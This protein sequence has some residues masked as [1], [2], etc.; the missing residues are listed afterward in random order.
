MGK[1]GKGKEKEVRWRRDLERA[2]STG[3]WDGKCGTNMGNTGK[4]N[5]RGK[6]STWEE[7]VE[8]CERKYAWGR[9]LERA[10]STGFWERKC[11]IKREVREIEG[12]TGMWNETQEKKQW[13]A[14]K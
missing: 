11:G 2:Y 12:S 10:C 5:A 8:G 4:G 3:F 6:G 13:L 9:D 7:S 1:T 14:G